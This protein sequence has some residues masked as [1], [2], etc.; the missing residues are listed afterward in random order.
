MKN[1]LLCSMRDF[2]N[3]PKMFSLQRLC[4]EEISA[5]SAS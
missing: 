3:V 1:Y 4:K 2:E 5:L